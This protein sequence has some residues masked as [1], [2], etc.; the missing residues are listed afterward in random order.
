MIFLYYYSFFLKKENPYSY[1][2]VCQEGFR[3]IKAGLLGS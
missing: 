2:V 3:W 1:T